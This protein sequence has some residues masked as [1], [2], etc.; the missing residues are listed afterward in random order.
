MTFQVSDVEITTK[1]L[2]R[3]VL[4]HNEFAMDAIEEIDRR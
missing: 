1:P 2:R 3:L 4:V